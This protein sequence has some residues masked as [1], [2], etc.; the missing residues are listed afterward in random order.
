MGNGRQ[1]KRGCNEGQNRRG[2]NEEQER[3]RHISGLRS[4]GGPA[5]R[6]SW[7]KRD[8]SRGCWRAIK[9]P[10]LGMI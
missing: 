10:P 8:G 3:D 1:N 5:V 2:C 9:I 6:S 7:W 4:Q